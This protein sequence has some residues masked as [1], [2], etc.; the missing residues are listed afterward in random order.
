MRAVLLLVV[1]AY[2]GLVSGASRYTADEIVN[3][4]QLPEEML[5]HAQDFFTDPQ[6][7]RVSV[8]PISKS[9]GSYRD[10]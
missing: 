7:I 3:D 9:N 1:L 10:Q 8:P 6:I 2:V 5:T 4:V